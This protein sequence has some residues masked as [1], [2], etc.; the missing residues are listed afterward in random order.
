M[1]KIAT[2]LFTR[3]ELLNTITTL[4][5][6]QHEIG[7]SIRQNGDRAIQNQLTRTSD[8]LTD[9][10]LRFNMAT[11]CLTNEPDKV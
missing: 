3:D 9:L 5:R 1:P 10:I 6:T 2:M 8:E 11:L 7:Y 4:E